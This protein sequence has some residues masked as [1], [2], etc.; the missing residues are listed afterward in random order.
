MVCNHV[1]TLPQAVRVAQQTYDA[2]WGL[3]VSHFQIGLK[4]PPLQYDIFSQTPGAERG[5]LLIKLAELVER[6]IDEIAAIE[7]LDNGKTFAISKQVDVTSSAAV[8]RY[9]GGWA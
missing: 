7:A 4:P 1:L 2:V 6:D 3:K 8:L 5:K 9:Y